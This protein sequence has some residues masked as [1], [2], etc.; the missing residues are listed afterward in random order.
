[1][2]I[3]VDLVLSLVPKVIKLAETG[4]FLF[5]FITITHLLL[6]QNKITTSLSLSAMSLSAYL[7]SKVKI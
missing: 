4:M 5:K 1:M 3:V 7:L 6:K 2:D